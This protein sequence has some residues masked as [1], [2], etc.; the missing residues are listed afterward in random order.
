M[1]KE[2]S[3]SPFRRSKLQFDRFVGDVMA[4][5]TAR[6][7][8]RGKRTEYWP[9]TRVPKTPADG[10]RYLVMVYPLNQHRVQPK[11]YSAIVRGFPKGLPIPEAKKG[12]RC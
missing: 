8:K 4:G 3:L 10:Q 2:T 6:R 7:S 11:I 5:V 1:A 9:G 12:R